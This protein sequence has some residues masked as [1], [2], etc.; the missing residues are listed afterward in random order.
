MLTIVEIRTID[1]DANMTRLQGNVAQ[2][3]ARLATHG[4]MTQDGVKL[5]RKNWP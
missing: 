1:H 5:L 2:N 4:T 3:F